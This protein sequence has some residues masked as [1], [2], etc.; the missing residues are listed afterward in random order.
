MYN[1]KAEKP[2]QEMTT[3][4]I[5]GILPS[6]QVTTSSAEMYTV[7]NNHT[8]WNQSYLHINATHHIG[9]HLRIFKKKILLK[10]NSLNSNN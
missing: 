5:R 9:K 10:G 2:M 1:I 4:Q 6:V 7:N 8:F 3:Q